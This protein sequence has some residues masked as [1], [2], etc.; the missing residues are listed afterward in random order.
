MNSENGLWDVVLEQGV[1]E[2]VHF[3]RVKNLSSILTHGLVPRALHAEHGISAVYTDPEPSSDHLEAVSLSVTCFNWP[4]FEEI[5][6]RRPRASWVVLAIEP[7]VLKGAECEFK[8]GSQLSRQS[9]AGNGP[10]SS[11]DDFRIMFD[12]VAVWPHY[13]GSS[14]RGDCK[15]QPCMTTDPQAEILF[16]G[17]VRPQHIRALW[18]DQPDLAPLIEQFCQMHGIETPEMHIQPLMPRHQ[19]SY[20]KACWG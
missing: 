7:E 9:L 12:D 18:F 6:R 14:F 4:L 19:T 15:L 10:A 16:R 17:R 13:R 3:T 1:Q 2:L 20:M 5:D 11:P 8:S